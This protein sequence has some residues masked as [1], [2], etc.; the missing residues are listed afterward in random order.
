MAA[1]FGYS[2]FTAFGVCLLGAGLALQI[3]Y[4][5]NQDNIDQWLPHQIS[6]LFINTLIVCYLLFSMMFYRPY[7][8]PVSIASVTL[9]LLSGLVLEF[10]FSQFETTS[11]YSAFEYGLAGINAMFRLYILISTRCD[12]PL[13][14]MPGL[15]ND[16]RQ[17]AR[18]SGKPVQDVLKDVGVATQDVD[19]KTLYGN[20]MNAVSSVIPDDKK[21]DT[22]ARI[23]KALGIQ[24]QGG[25]SR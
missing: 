14:T 1:S 12:Q 6:S 22:K 3:I 15:I 16:A 20:V 11:V 13:A 23:R 17:I 5:Q 25:R 4:I 21:D 10:Y 19:L 18:Q 9:F 24:Q 7:D 8:S 2:L